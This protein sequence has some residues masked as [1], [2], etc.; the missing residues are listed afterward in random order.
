MKIDIDIV[1]AKK[2]RDLISEQPNQE[3]GV[4]LV[5]SLIGILVLTIAMLAAGQLFR[6]HIESLVLA[7]RQRKAGAQAESILSD[8]AARTRSSLI[9]GGAFSTDS[10]GAP[11]RNTNNV[12]NA[13]NSITLACNT[14]YCDQ[15]LATP[16]NQGKGLTLTRVVYGAPA[17]E[18]ST[19][20]YTRAWNIATLDSAKGLRR[21]TVAVFSSDNNVPLAQ[22]QTSAMQRN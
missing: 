16:E 12:N 18:G 15:V 13:N 22:L 5:E 2:T 7:E 17:P 6:V 9:D 19:L 3:A 14:T 11:A 20:A 1:R 8:L 4:G 21:I 10:T